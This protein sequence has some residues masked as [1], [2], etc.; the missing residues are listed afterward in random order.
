ML[1]TPAFDDSNRPDTEVLK[2][3]AAW[4][5]ATYTRD[6]KLSGILYM[7]PITAARMSASFHRNMLLWKKLCGEASMG[8]VLLVTTF[9]N[10]ER[11]EECLRREQQLASDHFWG[12][13]IALGSK[14]FRQDE[15]RVS[16]EKIISYLVDRKQKLVLDIQKEMIDDKKGIEETT[17]G[18]SIH[19][20]LSKEIDRT[21]EALGTLREELNYAIS[22]KNT[23]WQQATQRA[24]AEAERRIRELRLRRGPI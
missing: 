2:E 19:S 13:P 23:E 7:H 20:E 12:K 1:D 6:V 10:T 8:G 3:I 5:G 22:Q 9:W 21:E 24:I 17:A 18:M 4:L 16:A 15:G 14:M 11:K